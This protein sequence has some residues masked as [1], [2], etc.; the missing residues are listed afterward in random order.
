M[1]R[2]MIGWSDASFGLTG[3]DLHIPEGINFECTSCA[4][5]CFGWPVPVTGDDRMR[6]SRLAGTLTTEPGPGDL[7]RER[8]GAD[9]KLELF[10]HTLGKRMDGKCQFLMLDNR[11]QLHDRFGIEAKPSMCRLFPYTFTETPVGFFASVSFASTGVLLNSGKPLT[12]QRAHLEDT[13]NLF[14]DLFGGVS[15]DWSGSQLIDGVPLSFSRYVELESE[16]LPA[17]MPVSGESDALGALT[18]ASSVV[19]G[20]APA[21]KNLD[22][23]VRLEA[24]PQVVDQ[25]VIKHLLDAYFPADVYASN[26]CDLDADCLAAQ[27][28]SPPDKVLFYCDGRNFRIRDLTAIK[29]GRLDDDVEGLLAR[30]AYCRVFSKLYFSRGFQSLSL[31]AGINH[32]AV[33]IALLKMIV[34]ARIFGGRRKDDLTILEVAEL[35]RTLERRLTVAR[36]S[37]KSKAVLEV[38]LSSP[39]RLERIVSLAD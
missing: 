35:V 4:N 18:F 37:E 5:C 36:F 16:F 9:S 28:V 34:K 38:L 19:A 10:T 8:K 33:I 24:R 23:P 39:E 12:D 29:L 25:L 21:G 6:I 13:L 1:I 14:K 20:Q 15:P 7:F 30:F 11:C 17:L 22:Q 3:V 2:F 31:L 27:L 32:L 26:D